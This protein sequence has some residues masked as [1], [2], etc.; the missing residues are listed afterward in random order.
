MPF[1]FYIP[2]AVADA[3]P[4]HEVKARARAA[5]IEIPRMEY[6]SIRANRGHRRERPRN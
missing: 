4:I 3:L 2:N 6:G 5:N 1:Q